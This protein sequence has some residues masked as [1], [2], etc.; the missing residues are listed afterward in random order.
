MKRVFK[1]PVG[2]GSIVSLYLPKDA[3]ILKINQLNNSLIE[4]NALYIWTMI[5]DNEPIFEE[6]TFHIYGTGHPIENDLKL[7]YIDTLFTKDD[8]LIWHIFENKKS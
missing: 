7:E 8:S 4:K 3:K 5:D 6:R 2:F 1:Y